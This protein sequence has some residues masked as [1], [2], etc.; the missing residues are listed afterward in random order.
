[1]TAVP[2]FHHSLPVSSSRGLSKGKPLKNISDNPAFD[3]FRAT[4]A[5][6]LSTLVQKALWLSFPEEHSEEGVAEAAA[7]YFRTKKGDAISPRTVRYWLRGETLPSA[8]H[9]STLVVMQPKLFLGFWLGV[10]Q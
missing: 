9:L 3:E 2:S 4:D 8:L 5:D 10:G 6:A 1:M 7:P